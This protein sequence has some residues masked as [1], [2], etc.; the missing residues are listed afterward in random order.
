MGELTLKTRCCSG[1]RG[2]ASTSLTILPLLMPLL[3]RQRRPL[4]VGFRL[5]RLKPFL[6]L[7][8]HNGQEFDGRQHLHN[9]TLN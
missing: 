8:C 1:A 6:S 3:L 5:V 9:H 4:A 7:S 2:V